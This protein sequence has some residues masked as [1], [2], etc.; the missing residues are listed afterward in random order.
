MIIEWAEKI[1]SLL[2]DDLLYINF[3]ILSAR[4]RRMAFSTAGKRFYS[5]FKELRLT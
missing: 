5:L 4:K 1:M 3:E 2:P